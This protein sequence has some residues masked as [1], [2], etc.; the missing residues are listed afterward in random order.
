ML[1]GV[2]VRGLASAGWRQ[3][4]P[5]G[6]DDWESRYAIRPVV[7]DPQVAAEHRGYC[8]HGAGWTGL[9][10]TSGRRGP[11]S[12]VWAIAGAADWRETLCRA[13]Y[14]PV[15]T[16]AGGYDGTEALDWAGR[17]YGRSHHP[18]G[19]VC[20][21]LV[22]R[23]RVGFRHLGEDLP[24]IFPEQNE[25]VAARR[26][27]SNPGVTMDPVL[28]PPL[29]ATVDRCRP[30]AVIRA[31]QDPTTVKDSGLSTTAGLDEL[32]G[33]GKGSSG[34]LAVT[35]AGRPLGGFTMEATCRQAPGADSRRWIA[36]LQRAREGAAAGPGTRGVSVCDREGDCWERL[37]AAAANG[38]ALLVCLWEHLAEGAPVTVTERVIP[39]AGGPRAR[40][41]RPVRLAIRV[42]A[43]QLVPTM[44]ASVWPSMPSPPVGSRT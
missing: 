4:V 34:L 8:Y 21:R 17:E 26:R 23:G 11:V 10:P 18:D 5:P 3:A 2:R 35:P 9:G 25:Q 14:R 20:A 15:G 37:S 33:G 43:V 1:P 41:G 16:L 30:E 39:A 19:R 28:E 6:I 24:V 27:L 32:G 36:G 31:V 42:E 44:G 29:E 38:D 40:A 22:E 12:R 7:I 13:P